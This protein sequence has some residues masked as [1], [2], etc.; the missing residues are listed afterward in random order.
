[1][2]HRWQLTLDVGWLKNKTSESFKLDLP[3]QGRIE[4]DVK[5]E[6]AAGEPDNRK[7]LRVHLKR[8]V[9]LKASDTGF[10]G[11]GKSD[12]LVNRFT[13]WRYLFTGGYVGLATVGVYL[14]MSAVWHQN[15]K[16]GF[17]KSD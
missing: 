12:P 14:V 1:M 13:L 3:T 10:M 17:I 7:Y 6:A 4:F 16:H 5:W 15:K 11:S 8:A 2:P 9:N